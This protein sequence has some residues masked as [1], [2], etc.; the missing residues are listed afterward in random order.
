MSLTTELEADYAARQSAAVAAACADMSDTDIEAQ[1]D[2]IAAKRSAPLYCIAISLADQDNDYG[3]LD[4]LRGEL[5]RRMRIRIEADSA[6]IDAGLARVAA[7]HADT[8]SINAAAAVEARRELF[9]NAVAK[10]LDVPA[11]AAE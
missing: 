3:L 2:E 10:A 8:A 7:I 11:V 6:A 9:F 1:I 5:T 4:Q